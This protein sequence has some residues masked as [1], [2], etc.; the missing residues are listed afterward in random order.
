MGKNVPLAAPE[1]EFVVIGLAM[2]C[3]KRENG[4][5]NTFNAS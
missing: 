2:D 4:N 1:T 5:R 3:D